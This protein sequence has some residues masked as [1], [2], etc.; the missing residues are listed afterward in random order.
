MNDELHLSSVHGGREKERGRSSSFLTLAVNQRT[1]LGSLGGLR[2][3]SIYIGAT[4]GERRSWSS[5]ALSARV[6]LRSFFPEQAEKTGDLQPATAST[7]APSPDSAM[8]LRSSAL[9]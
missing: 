3:Q 4:V 6:P 8:K 9:R 1:G 5:I 2:R 7:M